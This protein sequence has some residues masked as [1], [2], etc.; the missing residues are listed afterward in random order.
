MR[1]CSF[2]FYDDLSWGYRIRPVNAD[3]FTYVYFIILWVGTISMSTTSI[4]LYTKPEMF[5]FIL[6][7]SELYTL[8]I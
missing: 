5:L 7:N 6:L 2:A 3:L 4:K 1:K 8:Y